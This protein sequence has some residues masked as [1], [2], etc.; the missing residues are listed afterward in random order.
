M[1]KN[2]KFDYLYVNDFLKILEMF[3]KKN[4][5]YQNYNI[6]TGKP[7]EFLEI[8]NLIN[9]IHENG[10]GEITIKESGFNAEYSGDNSRFLEEFDHF[11]YTDLR[12]SIEELYNWYK[13][14]SDINN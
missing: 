2:M 5:K 8:A 12:T 13:E 1:N 10:K 11:E 3:F 4:L 14:S 7:V 9:D 6:C